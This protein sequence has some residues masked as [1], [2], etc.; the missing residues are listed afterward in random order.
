MG[1]RTSTTLV[2]NTGTPQGCVLLLS[3]FTHDCPPIHPTNTIVK[4]AD[5]TIIVGLIRDN[6]GSAYGEEVKHLTDWCF[7]NNLDLNTAKT[8]KIRKTVLPTLSIKGEEVERVESFK[9]LGVTSRLT[10]SVHT[11]YQVGKAHQHLYF[12][13]KVRQPY[14]PRPLLVNFYRA[15][16]QSILTYCCTVWFTSC[17]AENSKELQKVV[18]VAEKIIGTTPPPPQRHLH[19]PALQ[20]GQNHQH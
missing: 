14:L 7:H 16:I 15:T 19:R 8:K 1:K 4:F 20:E 11:S 18:R 3:L 5:D 9:F 13:R 17:T 10:S 12:L 6:D 2:L